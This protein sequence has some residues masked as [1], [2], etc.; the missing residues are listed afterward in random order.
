MKTKTKIIGFVFVILVICLMIG[1]RLS[2][3]SN[4]PVK[5]RPVRTSVLISSVLE[6][7]DAL[8][9]SEQHQF[10][11]TLGTTDDSVT[12]NQKCASFFKSRSN[13][14]RPLDGF[15]L[16]NGLF[17]DAWG[18]PLLFVMTND[19]T[20]NHINP[21]VKGSPRPFVIWSAGSNHTNELGYGDDVFTGQ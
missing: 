1:V 14:L 7:F 18:T 21:Q 11:L 3:I 2:T 13:N 12:I 8:E 17:R 10:I 19:A 20:Y 6:D 15:D 4:G 16:S 9:N 5:T